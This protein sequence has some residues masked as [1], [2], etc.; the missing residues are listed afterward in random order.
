MPPWANFSKG[1]S[2]LGKRD[3]VNVNAIHPGVTADRAARAAAGTCASK[4]SGK[5]VEQLRAEATAKD[6]LRRLGQPEDIAA[7]TLFLCSEGARHIQG[8]AIAVDGGSTVGYY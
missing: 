4:A 8:T 6:G 1:L 2:Q 3:G 5:T 7:L